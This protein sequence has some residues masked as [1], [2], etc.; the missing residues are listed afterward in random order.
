MEPNNAKLFAKIA[1]V[2]GQIRTLEKTGHNSFD[3]YDYIHADLVAQRIGSALAAA[4]VTFLPS[5]TG[6]DTSEY[7]PG[8]GTTNFRTVVT[9]QLTFGC[10]ETGATWTSL[11]AGE[12]IDR[13]DKSITKAITSSVKYFLLKTCLLGGGEE[14]DA[15][16]DSPIVE[17]RKA[18]PAKPLPANNGNSYHDDVLWEPNEKP[19][20]SD[21]ITPAQLTRLTILVTDFYG[22]EAKEQEVKLSQAVSKGAVSQFKELTVKEAQVLISGID[23]KMKEVQAA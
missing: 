7:T 8:K 13:S 9:M 2:M 20:K 14:E 23:K 4:G 19:K 15:D 12:A 17:T 22:S 1:A 21:A 11:W 16:A 5:V 3:K 10:T 18:T 6:C